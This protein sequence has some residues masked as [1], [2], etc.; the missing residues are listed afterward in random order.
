MKATKTKVDKV[1]KMFTSGAT[2]K[3]IALKLKM[4]EPEIT[5]IIKD[6]NMHISRALLKEDLTPDDPEYGKVRIRVN[7]NTSISLDKSLTADQ[8][9]D[10]VKEW[11]D[12]YKFVLD[13]D[14]DIALTSIRRVKAVEE[15]ETK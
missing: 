6:N 1:K 15:P 9:M 7:R 3:A 11:A 12:A 14:L 10:K 2:K 8:M 13:V 4:T 5:Q